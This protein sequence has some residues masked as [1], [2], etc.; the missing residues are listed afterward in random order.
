[1]RRK[2]RRSFLYLICR[3]QIKYVFHE[4]IFKV[5]KISRSH[6]VGSKTHHS[7]TRIGIISNNQDHCDTCD[8]RIGFGTGEHDNT[9]TCGNEATLST[10]NGD[11]QIKTM[12]YLL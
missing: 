10:D 3:R 6:A 8:S 5:Q 1:M 7:K 4:F 11:K 2:L 12:G 9:N